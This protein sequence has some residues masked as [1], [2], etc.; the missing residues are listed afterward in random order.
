M[1]VDI[2]P[3]NV[4]IAFTIKGLINYAFHSAEDFNDDWNGEIALEIRKYNQ[5]SNSVICCINA[6]IVYRVIFF[7]EK[8]SRNWI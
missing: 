7:L 2:P 6:L 4:V 3:V 1:A 8:K 5:L